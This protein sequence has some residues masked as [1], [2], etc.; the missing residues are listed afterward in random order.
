MKHFARLLTATIG[1]MS[2]AFVVSLVPQKAARGTVA[3]QVEVVNTPLPVTGSV[4]ATLTGTPTVNVAT[5]PPVNVSFPPSI[6]IN[7]S[8]PVTNPFTGFFQPVPLVVKPDTNN[9]V[10]LSFNTFSGIYQQ[11]L[12]DGSLSQSFVIPAGR[13]LVITDVSWFLGCAP[14]LGCVLSPGDEV[15]L[16]LGSFYISG[17]IYRNVIGAN[18]FFA[19]HADHLTTGL[20]MTQLPTPV[21]VPQ[22]TPELLGGIQAVILQG[23]L[24]P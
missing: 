1:L 24:T 18:Q 4:S 3:A 8:V 6:G 13:Q 21:L 12:P 5:M 20:V 15:N 11:V 7:G 19:S 16:T 10:S 23:Y 14:G 2:M 17:D 9:F 22:G